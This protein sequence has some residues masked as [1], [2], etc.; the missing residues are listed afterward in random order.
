MGALTPADAIVDYRGAGYDPVKVTLRMVKFRP[1]LLGETASK[2][3]VVNEHYSIS[4]LAVCCYRTAGDDIPDGVK[5][6]ARA[7]FD[8]K[9]I[10]GV[11]WPLT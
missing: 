2:P 10:Q 4:K 3:Y 1:T 7:K 9:D 8:T 5:D 11:E 6:R